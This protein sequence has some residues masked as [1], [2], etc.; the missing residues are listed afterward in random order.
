MPNPLRIVAEYR[1]RE[2]CCYCGASTFSG[3]YARIDETTV[4]FPRASA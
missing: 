3:I 4:P 1:D 2:N